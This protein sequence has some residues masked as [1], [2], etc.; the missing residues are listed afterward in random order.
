[1]SLGMT[2][3]QRY[4]SAV[5]STYTKSPQHMILWSV[6]QNQFA[7]K[8]FGAMCRLRRLNRYDGRIGKRIHQ[9][10]PSLEQSSSNRDFVGRGLANFL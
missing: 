9:L 3:K 7:G 8:S 6:L 5:L 4:Q 1:M 10:Q 2:Y